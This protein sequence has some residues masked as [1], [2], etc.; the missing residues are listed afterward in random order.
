MTNCDLIFQQAHREQICQ[1]LASR[2]GEERAAYMLFGVSDIATDPWQ[3]TRRVRFTSY[4]VIPIPEED[5]VSASGQH[6]TWKTNSFVKLCRRAKQEGLVVAIAHSHP[7]GTDAFSAQDDQNERDL[8]QLMVNRNGGEHPLISVLLVGKDTIRARAWNGPGVPDDCQR[9]SF[10]GSGIEV[11]T[12]QR[13][14]PKAFLDRQALAFGEDVNV[15]LRDLRVGVVGCGGTGSPVVHLL[16]RLGVGRMVVFDDDIV[17]TTNLNRLQGATNEDVSEKTPK[18]DVMVR[19]VNRMGLGVQ[20]ASIKGWVNT[21]EARDALKSCDVIFGCT[22]DHS[23]RLFLNRFAQFYLIPVID[24]GLVLMPNASGVSG[25]QEM[26]A[27]VSVLAPGAPCLVCR[28]T[29]NVT[30]AREEDLRRH[31]PEE[32]KA[33][34]NEAYVRG[35]GNP[36]PAVVTFTTEAATMAVNELL[37]GLVDFRAEGRW[38]WQ[39][40][41]RLDRATERLQGAPSKP[42]C[43]ICADP[44]IW[45]RADIEPFLD[46]TG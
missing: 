39:R 21:P 30:R 41:R 29:V 15:A 17:E 19:E 32:Y 25:L 11:S 16:A 37:Q 28:K 2:T 9:I 6:V 18:V 42:D 23:G 14:R 44:T 4:E 33:L 24:T 45:G 3:L 31:F 38:A 36:A 22:D 1:L 43:G 8:Y 7:G 34:K 13:D 20:I 10:I 35:S 26:A 46:R 40:Y 5:Y 27:R 12:I